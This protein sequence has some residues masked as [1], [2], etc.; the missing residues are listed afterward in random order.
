MYNKNYTNIERII[1]KIDNDFNPD[2]SDWIPRVGAWTI[3]AMNMLKVLRKEEKKVRLYPKDKI[4]TLPCP[5]DGVDFRV[6][7]SNGCEIKELMSINTCGCGND[8]NTPTGEDINTPITILNSTGTTGITYNIDSTNAPNTIVEHVNDKSYSNRYNVKHFV[9]SDEQDCKHY[10]KVGNNK[11]ELTFYTRYID[12]VTKQVK[13]IQSDVY[14]CDLPVIPNNGILIEAITYYCMY[15]MLCRGYTHPV[16]NLHASQYGTNPFFMW[17]QLKDEAKRS[18]I[19]DEQGEIIDDK[20]LWNS[21]LYI[22]TTIP[23]R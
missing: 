23:Q 13:T 11:L 10:V 3:D 14:N 5:V 2:N 16:F 12:F 15:K 7:D 19:I 21:T 9:K 22:N 1:A 4:V 8:A 20:G 6:Y 18:V 17:N